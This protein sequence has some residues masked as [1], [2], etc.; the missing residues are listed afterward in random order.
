[1]EKKKKEERDERF[2]KQ[3]EES[4]KKEMKE[5]TFMPKTISKSP[6]TERKKIVDSEYYT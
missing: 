2:K 5:C 6:I 1:M 3:R 4:L